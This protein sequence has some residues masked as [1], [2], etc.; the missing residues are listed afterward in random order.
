MHIDAEFYVLVG[1]AIFLGVLLWAGAHSKFAALVD[2]RIDKI[3]SELAEAERL[4]AEAETLL[5]SFEQKRVEA[6][7]EAKAI[8]A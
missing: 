7:A 5:A 2:A 8:V 3:K 6:E 4:R 1:F